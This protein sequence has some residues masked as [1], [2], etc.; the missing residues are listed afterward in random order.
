MRRVHQAAEGRAEQL[1]AVLYQ[2][3]APLFVYFVYRNDRFTTTGSGRPQETPFNNTDFCRALS[4]RGAVNT[5]LPN[6]G[7]G[8]G[9]GD[10]TTVAAAVDR[11]RQLPAQFVDLDVSDMGGLGGKCKEAGLGQKRPPSTHII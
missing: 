2:K 4:V 1:P 6:D 5:P 8:G 3:T 7:S 11:L 10:T 9:A